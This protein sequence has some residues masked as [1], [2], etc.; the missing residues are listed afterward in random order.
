[1]ALRQ[2]Y[3]GQAEDLQWD[4]VYDNTSEI[5]YRLNGTHPLASLLEMK[6]VRR[7]G[8]KNALDARGIYLG[9]SSNDWNE[10]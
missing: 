5:V 3:L 4:L 10:S 8:V 9:Q 1:M 2:V 6:I 7:C